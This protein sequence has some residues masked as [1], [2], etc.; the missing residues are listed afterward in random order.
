LQ[1]LC[2]KIDRDADVSSIV[3]ERPQAKEIAK[4][5]SCSP[6]FLEV[7]G[8]FIHQRKNE[9]KAYESVINFLQTGEHF[10]GT[11]TYSFDESR[12]LFSYDGLNRNA[13]E[14]F[15]DICSFFYNWELEEVAWIV[16]EEEFEC[17]QEGALLKNKDGRISIH[18][19]ILSAGRNKCKDS[20]FTTASELSKALKKE[21]L[22]SQ[23]KG[24]WLRQN[25]SPFHIS[26]EELDVMSTSLR[27]FSMGNL[28][29][30]EGKCQKQF[31]E[32]R[33]FQVDRV[34]NLPMDI[35]N[36]KHLSYIDYA[37]GK[38]M[39]LSSSK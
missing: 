7:V 23:I 20:R 14:A 33:Y 2:R 37:F 32:L 6:L 36:L 21:E 15:L 8:G 24:V 3:A 10:S 30:V 18:D 34:P 22:V 26:A 9:K 4:K 38:D 1:V 12:V 19:L 31:D 17:L 28:T 29:I 5:C 39:I 13:Q 35:S 25:G 11:K 16:G 27:V